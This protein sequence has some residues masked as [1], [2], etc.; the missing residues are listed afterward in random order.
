MSC[1]SAERTKVSC[2]GSDHGTLGFALARKETCSLLLLFLLFLRQ[3]DHALLSCLGAKQ[4]MSC[5]D[6]ETMV[7]CLDAE[8]M[9]SC[10]DTDCG[11]LTASYLETD[12]GV[13]MVSC[14]DTDHGVLMVS[15]LETD[16]DVLVVSCLNTDH[17]VL[18]GH[19]AWCL[20]FR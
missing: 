15:C 13:L 3:T 19:R 1:F 20:V 10:L 8:T 5:L 16:H 4:T 18:F 6:T 9:V 2:F 7:S 17:G 14:L 11:V 12:H